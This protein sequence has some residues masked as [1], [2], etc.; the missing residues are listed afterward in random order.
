MARI[1]V[2]G[3]TEGV[4]RATADD[5]LDDGHDIVVHARSR[6]RLEA[7]RDLIERG[8]TGVVGDLADPGQVED[9]A[10]QANRG[11]QPDPARLD[12]PGAVSYSDSKLLLTALMSAIGRRR[13]DLVAH[14]VDPGWVPTRMGGPGA[15]DDLALPHV[16]QTWL[17]TTDDPEALVSSRYWHYRPVEQPHA[18]VLDAAFGQELVAA[19]AARTGVDL[20]AG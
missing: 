2:T 10:G 15:S 14:A 7:V 20:P 3:S 4:G 13:P 16:T 5:L 19:L 6:R 9:F 8:A 17:A 1:L 18:A 11:G 12:R